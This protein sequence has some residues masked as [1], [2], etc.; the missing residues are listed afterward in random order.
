MKTYKIPAELAV[1]IFNDDASGLNNDDI[2]AFKQFCKKEDIDYCDLHLLDMDAVAE[3]SRTNDVNGLGA[4]VL[5]FIH[6]T[7]DEMTLLSEGRE[8]LNALCE[9]HDLKLSIEMF[10]LVAKLYQND[11]ETPLAE[12]TE[13]S[14]VSE[15]LTEAIDCLIDNFPKTSAQEDMNLYL[16]QTTDEWYGTSDREI[17]GIYSSEELA[18]LSAMKYTGEILKYESGGYKSINEE[19]E[20]GVYITQYGLDQEVEEN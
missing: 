10:P 13:H 9:P 1:F 2:T 4:D 15:M 20:Q 7:D 18:L 16:A 8:A 19:F 12:T 3:F 14:E 17:I 5:E 6:Y 11:E